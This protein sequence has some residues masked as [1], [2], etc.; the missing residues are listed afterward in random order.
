MILYFHGRDFTILNGG[1]ALHC[2]G[3]YIYV[4][5][6]DKRQTF[7]L[8]NSCN[9]QTYAPLSLTFGE[10]LPLPKNNALSIYK[11]PNATYLVH[12]NNPKLLT[13]RTFYYATTL[14]ENIKLCVTYNGGL[15]ITV[16]EGITMHLG[17][18]LFPTYANAKMHKLANRWLIFLEI[19]HFGGVRLYVFGKTDKPVL[20]FSNDVVDY[21]FENG[22]LKTV[23]LVNDIFSHRLEI[24]WQFD[25]NGQLA[26]K[27]YQLSATQKHAY[28]PALLPAA[29]LQT[30]SLGGNVK[31]FLTEE[32]FL[33]F[34][35]L[36]EFFGDYHKQVI[37]P[38]FN[39]GEI[40]LAYK[41]TDN[42]YQCD[43]YHFQLS[44]DRIAN[45]IKY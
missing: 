17:S 29:F 22:H 42:I 18:D 33:R 15:S 16:T 20:L 4:D 32:L 9:D 14:N 19:H 6:G 12:F 26:V 41:Q 7:T 31:E 27:N 8:L 34:N 24:I 25:S 10:G 40:A 37:M 21:F 1:Q 3:E 28:L 5:I 39:F 44:N 45:V 11:L 30:L 23:S 35:D 36:K 38:Y 2:Q 43:I 13:E